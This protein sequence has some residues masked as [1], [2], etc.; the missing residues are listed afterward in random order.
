M[1]PSSL[2]RGRGFGRAVLALLAVLLL[3]SGAVALLAPSIRSSTQV[4]TDFANFE[5]LPVRPLAMTPDGSRLLAVNLPDARL[6]VFSIQD[7]SLT[8]VGE[9]PIELDPISVAA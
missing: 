9:V 7:G 6:E 2:P 4:S 3:V 8:S 5:S 1:T